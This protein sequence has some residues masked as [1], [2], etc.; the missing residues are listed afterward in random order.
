MNDSLAPQSSGG[1]VLG[2]PPRI[3]SNLLIS[4]LCL[5]RSELVV[6]LN[7]LSFQ[8]MSSVNR[9]A[10]FTLLQTRQLVD[11]LSQT[12]LARSRGFHPHVLAINTSHQ[13]GQDTKAELPP[14]SE[15]GRIESAVLSNRDMRL[16]VL[17]SN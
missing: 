10:V 8:L 15:S 2:A 13:P 9:Y 5:R 17:A 7:T 12:Q 11:P 4:L 1:K 14:M 3:F 16:L 6:L